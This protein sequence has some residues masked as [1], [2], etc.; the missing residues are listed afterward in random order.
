MLQAKRFYSIF[1]GR[2]RKR[3][4]RPLKPQSGLVGFRNVRILVRMEGPRPEEGSRISS[5][6]LSA[7]VSMAL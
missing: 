4:P 1:A 2:P 5:F 6:E 3:S 7:S